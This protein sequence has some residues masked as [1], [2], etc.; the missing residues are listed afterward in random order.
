MKPIL[1]SLAHFVSVLV[2]TTGCNPQSNSQQD[3]ILNY[4]NRAASIGWKL[5]EVTAGQARDYERK[6][7]LANKYALENGMS[8]LGLVKSVWD[9]NKEKEW[10]ERRGEVIAEIDNNKAEN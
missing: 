7:D 8:A 6:I 5:F 1:V 9:E 10:R 4:Q 2:L 3:A